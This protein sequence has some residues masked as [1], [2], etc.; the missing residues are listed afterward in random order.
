MAGVGP[1]PFAGMMLADHGAEVIRIDRPD[2][3]LRHPEILARSRKSVVVD[4]K[5]AQGVALVRRLACSAHGLFEGLRPGVMERLG[6]GPEVLLGDNPALVYGR[7]TGW[8]QQ[9]PL[10]PRAG[11]DINYIALS[12][13]LHASGRAGAPPTPP[14]NL[15]GDFGGGGMMMAFGMV[16]ALLNARNTGRGQV[17]DCAMVDGASLL[18]SATYAYRARGVWSDERGT[19]LLDSGAH[20]YD[21]YETADGRHVAIGSIEPQFYGELRVKLGTADDPE[22]DAQHDKE[23]WPRLKEKIAAIFRQRTLEDWCAIFEGSDACFSPVLTMAEAPLH[24]HNVV[25]G[26]FA[27]AHG[28]VQP[29]PAP[30]F[31][32]TPSAPPGP[33]PRRGNDTDAVLR[34]LGCGADEIAELRTTG[35]VL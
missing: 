25:R 35:V 14:I 23:Q 19:N 11:H 9:G 16:A 2:V 22:F 24:Q 31:S 4:L 1:A 6:L 17:I 21:C 5:Q 8:G 32:V 20:F 18:M 34:D 10:A 13:A 29:T 33:E 15:V 26:T 30:R 27:D 28:T 3:S 12:G 7:M